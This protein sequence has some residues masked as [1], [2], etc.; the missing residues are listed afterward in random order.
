MQIGVDARILVPGYPAVLEK[1]ADLQHVRTIVD[2]W[3]TGGA[4]LMKGQTPD[5]VPAT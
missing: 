2:P 5:G 4:V 1:M 3:T